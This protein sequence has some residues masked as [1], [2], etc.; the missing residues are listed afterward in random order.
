MSL[1]PCIA[2]LDIISQSS[3]GILG[4]TNPKIPSLQKFASH[5]YCLLKGKFGLDFLTSL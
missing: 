4:V 2:Y 3:H 5:K 1:S